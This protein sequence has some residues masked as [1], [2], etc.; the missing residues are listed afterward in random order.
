MRKMFSL[1]QLTD[2][3]ND[4]S[5][6]TIEEYKS[7]GKL[8][9][10]ITIS[11]TIQLDNPTSNLEI[12][13]ELLEVYQKHTLY[14]ISITDSTNEIEYLGIVFRSEDYFSPIMT[15]DQDGLFNS[16]GLINLSND[17]IILGD[18]FQ[19]LTDASVDLIAIIQR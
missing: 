2:I 3:A 12:P 15:I 8:A 17:T 5:E 18:D 4:I 19:G 1:K 7:K 13:E 10:N 9:S 16:M 11:F 14:Y 6:E